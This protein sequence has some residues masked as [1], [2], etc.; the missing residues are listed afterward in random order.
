[1]PEEEVRAQLTI[2]ADFGPAEEARDAYNESLKDIET[3]APTGAPPG[4]PPVRGVEAAERVQTGF[5]DRLRSMF[6]AA[7]TD[8]AQDELEAAV[9]DL[10]REISS[11]AGEIR[12]LSENVGKPLDIKKS[13]G[14]DPTEFAAEI[15]GAFVTA[16]AITRID[17]DDIGA[18]VA[19]NIPPPPDDDP[20]EAIERGM[21]AARELQRRQAEA[22]ERANELIEKQS[23]TVAKIADEISAQAQVA[24]GAP[25]AAEI[26]VPLAQPQAA[27]GI[28]AAPPDDAL[29]GDLVDRL[30]EIA[31]S[32]KFDLQIETG[33]GPAPEPP[34]DASSIQDQ[35]LQALHDNA[36]APSEDK[37]ARIDDL[38]RRRDEENELPEPPEA[39]R[40]ELD[41][42]P[43]VAPDEPPTKEGLDAY[44]E[45]AKKEQ[46]SIKKFHELMGD[47]AKLAD[48]RLAINDPRT[49]E[50]IRPIDDLPAGP[51]PGEI[52]FSSAEDILLDLADRFDEFIQK[53]EADYEDVSDDVEEFGDKLRKAADEFDP[54]GLTIEEFNRSVG[55]LTSEFD[56]LFS[57]LQEPRKEG[58]DFVPGELEQ[59]DELDQLRIALE[60][61]IA[62]ANDQAELLRGQGGRPPEQEPFISD[63]KPDDIS[64]SLLEF[65]DAL[66]DAAEGIGESDIGK[67]LDDL[68]REIDERLRQVSELQPP[69][70]PPDQAALADIGQD[71]ST[72]LAGLRDALRAAGVDV[73]DATKEIVDRLAGMAEQIGEASRAMGDR[74]EPQ[75][76]DD[77]I[78]EFRDRLADAA[79]SLDEFQRQIFTALSGTEFQDELLLRTEEIEDRLKRLSEVLAEGDDIQEKVQDLRDALGEAADT[80]A[81]IDLGGA[82]Q[83]EL[84][85]LSQEIHSIIADVGGLAA[86]KPDV[87]GFA[88]APPEMPDIEERGRRI[89]EGLKPRP[90]D[91]QT[92]Q[93]LEDTIRTARDTIDRLRRDAEPPSEPPSPPEAPPGFG[94][95]EEGAPDDNLVELVRQIRDTSNALLEEA[96]KMR[97]E[98]VG[99]NERLADELGE[100]ADRAR[101]DTAGGRTAGAPPAIPGFGR[102]IAGIGALFGVTLGLRSIMGVLQE[103]VSKMNERFKTEAEKLAEVNPAI[104]LALAERKLALKLLDFAEAAQSQEE[105]VALIRRG[106][107]QLETE[108]AI[109]GRLLDRLEALT[110][111]EA[112]Q[113]RVDAIGKLMNQLKFLGIEIKRTANELLVSPLEEDV[114][115]LRKEQELIDLNLQ[116]AQRRA[117]DDLLAGETI[118][119][120]LLGL[121]GTI[122]VGFFRF[123]EF[124][125]VGLVDLIRVN[126]G[127]GQIGGEKEV[128][129][130]VGVP[131]PTPEPRQPRPA[132]PPRAPDNPDAPRPP[133]EQQTAT[134]AGLTS[135]QLEE[136]VFRALVRAS[137]RRSPSDSVIPARFDELFA[138][139]M[140]AALA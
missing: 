65:Q 45:A 20:G 122:G 7:G 28:S 44:L 79:Q 50:A 40:P 98:L 86:P 85:K 126:Q 84:E 29:G 66:R 77:T 49:G 120:Q 10:S 13:L 59:L 36:I 62:G 48:E 133:A 17:P 70:Q 140:K 57:K 89:G 107:A 68:A 63:A 134:P 80:A 119:D 121:V 51:A 21:E 94:G 23:A 15:T 34:D 1:M 104:A 96:Q 16:A 4:A 82:L 46:E 22:A 123:S 55:S 102:L 67:R 72:D 5:M 135:A 129:R 69:D 105:F 52:D 136:A 27:P 92:T 117:L 32:G 75:E 39:P 30:R 106:T 81:D 24:V 47:M 93:E 18:A 54:V 71:V 87:S 25:T 108:E 111:E 26:G 56:E 41:L 19:R 118:A 112:R 64:T 42:G 95:G 128:F 3:P 43:L 90:V 74:V 116:A 2:D 61:M 76:A 6:G 99:S 37:V 139:D 110:G 130:P 14:F 73:P 124:L 109:R 137:R 9:R 114:G 83:D 60:R 115:S 11:L 131:T 8:A 33:T 31:K 91:E 132:L 12:T 100:E 88:V 103:S 125:K 38:L 127:L 58:A 113:D 53:Q 97:G 138:A 35:L 101:A 78:A